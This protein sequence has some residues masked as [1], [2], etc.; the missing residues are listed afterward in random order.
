MKAAKPFLV[1]NTVRRFETRTFSFPDSDNILEEQL[2]NYIIDR[3]TQTGTPVY[4][5]QDETKGD[6]T[7]DAV[8]LALVGF[9]LEKTPLG[10]PIYT[11]GITFSGQFGEKI[12]SDVGQ[13]ELIINTNK[14]IDAKEAHKPQPNR[15]SGIVQER[16]VIGS[17]NSLPANNTNKS[18]MVK[19]WSWDGFGRD[20]ERPKVRSLSEAFSEAEKR[21]GLRTSNRNG[22]KP[23]RRN[24]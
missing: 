11:T 16:R 3:I 23:R 19:L 14:K 9:T 5:P 22:G 2:S 15:T 24:I 7:L 13:G 12:S 4:K 21:M 20:E 18:N 10:H 1:E 6:H 17:N 8:M